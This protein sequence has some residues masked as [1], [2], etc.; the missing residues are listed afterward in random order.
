M[1]LLSPI[2]PGDE[3]LRFFSGAFIEEERRGKKDFEGVGGRGG[4]G[5]TGGKGEGIGGKGHDQAFSD[6]NGGNGSNG[7]FPDKTK[8]GIGNEGN[9]IC[10]G[11]GKPG[12]KG[13]GGAF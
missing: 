10:V 7:R 3:K 12:G 9:G 1:Q 6:G 11:R 4:G 5:G 8:G 2:T 13:G